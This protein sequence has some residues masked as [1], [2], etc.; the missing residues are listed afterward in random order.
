MYASIIEAVNHLRKAG[1]PISPG[2]LLD[3]CRAMQ[4]IELR[5]EDALTAAL[6]TLAKD[7]HAGDT[8]AAAIADY[9]HA[10]AADDHLIIPPAINIRAAVANQP[11]LKD[12]EFLNRLQ[13]I[14]DSIRHEIMLLNEA[15]IPR[16]SGTGPG[17]NCSGGGGKTIDKQRSTF[18]NA[19]CNGTGVLSANNGLNRQPDNAQHKAINNRQGKPQKKAYPPGP[20]N[21]QQLDLAQADG[22]QL[23]EINKIL[24]SIGRRLAAYKGYRKKPSTSG[25]VD[26]RRTVRQASARGGLPLVLKKMQRVPGKPRICTM[27]DLSG[28]MAPYS[29]F[30]LQLLVSLQHK[31]SKMKSFAFVDRIA[32]V[33]DLAVTTGQA[34]NIA[35]RTILREARISNTGFSNYGLVWEQ[36]NQDFLHTL[37][38]QTTLIILGDA[39]NNWQPDGIE[40]LSSIT[41]R[42]RRTIW[43]NPLPRVSWSKNDCVMET[44]VPFCSLVLEC[45]NVL[46][47]SQ[48]IREIISM[49]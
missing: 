4:I 18:A 9:L 14:K 6:C 36:F 25:I 30:F 43:L 29:V 20:T 2:E 27:C 49:Q 16:N 31:F 8:L 44:Y 34:W 37:T 46:Q 28:S 13:N 11:R 5:G 33:T 35:A 22:E 23:A 19:R 3:F 41:S 26:M 15:N 12:Q 21:L 24:T 39:R 42:C 47:L 40:Y 48:A 1:L 32:E 7:K 38:P 17:P 10:K 45:R